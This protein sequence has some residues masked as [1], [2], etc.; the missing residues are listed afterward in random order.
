[1]FSCLL[2]Y[3]QGLDLIMH[4]YEQVKIFLK[5]KHLKFSEFTPD[6]RSVF[7]F[8]VLNEEQLVVHCVQIDETKLKN[9][10][11]HYFLHLSNRALAV[12]KKLIHL[13]EDV[14]LNKN[15]IV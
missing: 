10:P 3:L 14:W 9:L 12:N 6:F 11:D 1:M 13:W 2:F 5:E 15:E 4:F 7:G 8:L